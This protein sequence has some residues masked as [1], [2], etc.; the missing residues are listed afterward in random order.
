MSSNDSLNVVALISGGKDSFFSILHC[1]KNGHRVIALANLCPAGFEGEEATTTTTTTTTDSAST[2]NTLQPS[3]ND[4]EID[5]HM[6]QTVGAR[7]IP[8]YAA[9][10][11]L[12]LYRQPISGAAINTDR[13]YSPSTISASTSTSTDDN[14]NND[15]TES[16]LPLL[17]QVLAAHPEVNALC[18]GA[19]L[20][21]YQ[22][23]R[24]ESVALR[25]GL[26]PLAYLW[27]YPYLPP[28]TQ[29]SLLRDMASVGQDARVIKVA[30]G[31]LDE[32]HL[33]LNVADAAGVTV[34]KLGREM[35]RFGGLVGGSV[36]G[37]G[38]EYETLAVDGP[39]GVWKRRVV[40]EE[41][42]RKVFGGGGVWSLGM[43]GAVTVEKEVVGDEDDWRER[44]RVP[45]V[46]D[47]E[48]E[49]LLGA[50]KSRREDGLSGVAQ[51]RHPEAT[52]T[53][54]IKP[55]TRLDTTPLA[56]LTQSIHL[57]SSTL[58]ISNLHHPVQSSTTP[59][60]SATPT[61]PTT[62]FTTIATTLL[63]HLSTNN[64]TP[65]HITHT[66]ILLRSMSLFSSINTAYATLFTAPNP[67]SRV[68]V[69]CG[70]SL[71]VGVDVVLSAICHLPRRRRLG[72][73]DAAGHGYRYSNDNDNE[74][75]I[76]LHVQS[77]SYWA[78][79]NIGPYSQAISVPLRHP[80]PNI[81]NNNSNDN[82]DNNNNNAPRLIHIA[83]QIP[84]T[85]ATMSLHT[86]D[87][88][89]QAVLS[90]QHL[91]R[92]GRAMNVDWW[93]GCVTYVT[94]TSAADA[95]CRAR[96]VGEVWR[97]AHARGFLEDG[98]REDGEGDED[99]VIDIAELSL[100]GGGGYRA[101]AH[102][103]T[104]NDAP[105]MK[106]QRRPLPNW[107][108]LSTDTNTNINIKDVTIA[109]PP[110][111]TIQVSALPRASSIEW[112][113]LGLSSSHTTTIHIQTSTQDHWAHT[114]IHTPSGDG[115]G[116]PLRVSVR[117]V[118]HADELVGMMEEILGQNGDEDK[119]VNIGL[120]EVFMPTR[121]NLQADISRLRGSVQVVPCTR[122]W[123]A[124]GEEV[125]A[126][127][128]CR[129]HA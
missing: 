72:D 75:R 123:D 59:S 20:S 107:D 126:V 8:L 25:L 15:E 76:G 34:G 47:V 80:V 86:P 18:T 53:T 74:E 128:R 58:Y 106:T 7:I 66:T 97:G 118:S 65:S 91:W 69:A 99:E 11:N 26:T 116:V 120:T 127:V 95:A 17:A 6:Y 92:I 79:A 41:E 67:P 105:S 62:Q 44:L 71:P 85:P 31:G 112:A 56:S 37:E 96:R 103:H 46:F 84:L 64:L 98:G 114:H 16:L 73:G 82:D 10:L 90:L 50:L 113:A 121:S 28:Y 12:P 77:R 48:F 119:D 57:T 100:R 101:W 94:A 55:T 2:N 87:F 68:T 110:I 108:V 30:S 78:P 13:D 45:D 4:E 109:I 43:K 51:T 115:S 125:F 49:R 39:G 42:G 19:I 24:I 61:S 23:T 102:T 70:D 38:G 32:R 1:L 3:T 27:Q 124:R 40:V 9:A 60:T 88:T 29:D 36:L 33:W 52:T 104:A 93:L 122:I 83:G 5:S 14:N 22:R 54:T 63:T 89:T 129:W 117:A 21:S 35:G 81:D 111:F